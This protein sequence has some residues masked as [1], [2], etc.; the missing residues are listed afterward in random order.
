MGSPIFINLLSDHGQ[1]SLETAK[2]LGLLATHFGEHRL[3]QQNHSFK[4]GEIMSPA[5]FLKLTREFF[6]AGTI[7]ICDLKI[8]STLPEKYLMAA[9]GYQFFIGPDSGIFA[10][11]FKDMEVQYFDLEYAGEITDFPT[12]ICI[13]AMQKLIGDNL[14]T[15]SFK[16]VQKIVD[17]QWLKPALMQNVYRLSVIYTD[18]RGNA[19]LNIS[20]D[21]FEAARK[22]RNFRIKV[23]MRTEI[24]Q[25]TAHYNRVP[26]GH[27]LALFGAGE[28]LQ[29]AL[30]WGSARQMLGMKENQKVVM[31]EFLD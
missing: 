25:I 13:P 18:A 23:D 31:L 8:K 9:S 24:N 4:L 30:N 6:P 3:I 19:Y 5:I 2:I 11:L 27:L 15:E 29:V 10:L 26:E 28:L 22:G 16:P 20:R 14:R 21:E 12:Q 1:N 7:H 17:A